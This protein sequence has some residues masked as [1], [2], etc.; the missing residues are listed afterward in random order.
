MCK[1]LYQFVE[2]QVSEFEPLVYSPNFAPDLITV[3]DFTYRLTQ[4]PNC[5]SEAG[6]AR[7]VNNPS[8]SNR[9][10]H[11]PGALGSGLASL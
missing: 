3:I 6:E 4:H 10:E 5:D 9:D 2:I 11:F 1:G 8:Q 7:G